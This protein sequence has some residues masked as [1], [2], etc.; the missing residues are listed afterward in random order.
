MRPPPTKTFG[1]ATEIL[2]H[3]DRIFED[4]LRAFQTALAVD[5]P[6]QGIEL[7]EDDLG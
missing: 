2:K 5:L 7:D 6:A 3:L 1:N 4:E